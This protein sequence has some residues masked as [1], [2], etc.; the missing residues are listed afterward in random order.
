[1]SRLP[2]TRRQATK[3]PDLSNLKHVL[4]DERVWCFRGKVFAPDGQSHWFIDTDG[5]ERRVY[6]HVQAI[7]SGLDVTCKLATCAGG[8][9]TGLW[10]IPRAG[11]NVLVDVS[12]GAIDGFPAIVAVEDSGGFP[13]RAGDTRVVMVT[14]V[15]IEITGPTVTL[16]PHPEAITPPD[17]LVHGSGIDP[18]TGAPYFAL[19]NCTS[20]VF[21]KKDG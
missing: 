7:P 4:R 10:F 5:G 6:V 9:G 8:A 19:G 3:R 17:A 15:P 18:F 12:D 14:N 1:V 21:A 16:G 11:T 13:D 2:P 20:V